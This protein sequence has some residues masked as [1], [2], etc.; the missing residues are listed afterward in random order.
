MENRILKQYEELIILDWTEEQQFVLRLLHK[1]AKPRLL[2]G[3]GTKE[4][5]CSTFSSISALQTFYSA[6]EGIR[7]F[8]MWTQV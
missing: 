4:I 6:K 8:K 1:T 7:Y 2:E 5:N 3:K